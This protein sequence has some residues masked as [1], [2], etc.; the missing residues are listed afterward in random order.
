[1]AK[2]PKLYAVNLRIDRDV[3]NRVAT[4]AN[5]C[6]LTVDQM[7]SAIVVL[8]LDKMHQKAAEDRAAELEAIIREHGTQLAAAGHGLVAQLDT[9]TEPS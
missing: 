9:P 1:M 8:E 7:A 2:K 5:Q 4:L 6:G 3:A